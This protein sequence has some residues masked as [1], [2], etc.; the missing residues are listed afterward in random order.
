M[1]LYILIFYFFYKNGK[2]VDIVSINYM[3]Y[4]GNLSL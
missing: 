3:Q 1:S 4:S 2:T